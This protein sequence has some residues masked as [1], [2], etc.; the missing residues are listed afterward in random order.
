MGSSRVRAPEVQQ[1]RAGCEIT[2]VEPLGQVQHIISQTEGDD[3]P[4]FT[5]IVG[6]PGRA[7]T[8]LE[9]L[10][11]SSST[12]GFAAGRL[13]PRHEESLSSV[14]RLCEDFRTD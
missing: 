7:T 11:R 1:I 4:Q 3:V 10:I 2:I 9:E 6:D 5:P 12:R 14:S 13:C 8:R